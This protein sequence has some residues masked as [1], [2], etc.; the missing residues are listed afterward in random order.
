M[1]E[2]YNPADHTVAE[3]K[4]YVEQNLDEAQAVLEAEQAGENRVTLVKHLEEVVEGLKPVPES[5]EPAPVEVSPG[6]TP[7]QNNVLGK[8]YDVTPESGYRL[9]K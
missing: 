1:P 3:V 6:P 8:N 9:S 7:T 5:V 4:E 2:E